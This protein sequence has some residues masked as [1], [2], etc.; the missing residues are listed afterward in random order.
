[1]LLQLPVFFA[2]FAVF[3]NTIELRQAEFVLWLR[4]LSQP[5][6]Y[7]VLPILMGITMF[8][9]QKMTVKDP[10][11]AAMVYIMPLV[12]T[13]LFIRF[14]SGLVL[15]WTMFNVLTLVQQFVF[16]GKASPA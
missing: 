8:V 11:Q 9:Q 7:Y 6:P 16:K 14:A 4:D 12:M 5:D 15:Y 13:F 3:R 10:K 2:L 1:M